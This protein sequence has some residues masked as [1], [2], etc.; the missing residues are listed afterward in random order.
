M[1]EAKITHFK[2]VTSYAH[3]FYFSASTNATSNHVSYEAALGPFLPNSMCAMTLHITTEGSDPIYYTHGA[4]NR[5][6]YEL[7]R[8]LL[9]INF[10]SVLFW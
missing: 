10:E 9:L 4:T 8:I 5:N 2:Y 6:Q 7:Y 1:H 3:F